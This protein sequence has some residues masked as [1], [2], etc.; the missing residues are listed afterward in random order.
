MEKHEPPRGFFG[1]LGDTLDTLGRRMARSGWRAWL[2]SRGN[3]LFAALVVGALLYGNRAG[4]LTAFI[5]TMPQTSTN[6]IAYQGRLAASGGA[7]LTG[8]YPMVFRLYGQSSGGA[9]LWDE[10]WT[11]PN[12]VRVSDGLFNV[13]LGSLTQIPAA[14]V[15]GN[16]TLW[17]GITVGTDGEMAPRVQ[18]GT[19]PYAM[20][21]LTVPD[22]SI[23]TPKLGDQSVTNA[24]LADGGVSAAKLAAGSVTNAKL[25][26]GSV[27][28]AKLG[29]DV[30]F[31][32]P[33]GSITSLKIADG[34]VD[35]V[36]LKNGAVTAAKLGD[37]ALVRGLTVTD[38]KMQWG[39]L[40]GSNT[41]ADAIVT[42]PQPFASAP[43]V[44]VTQDEAIGGYA[45]YIAYAVTAT[46]F[47]VSKPSGSVCSNYGW[48]VWIA[49]G[50]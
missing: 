43:V 31:V 11:G 23:G 35:T 46:G 14:L 9:P 13:M 3:V 28:A 45:H 49:I 16:T 32:P 1:T 19:V 6:T 7:P 42:F 50:N 12:G 20:Q 30:N 29:N 27:S 26:D 41:C 39:R 2:P 24:K 25:A 34:A 17:L 38:P 47:R 33:D 4:A 5:P 37:S 21:A 18:L 15:A 40:I 10:T 22:S 44:L 36:D 8:V 48:I